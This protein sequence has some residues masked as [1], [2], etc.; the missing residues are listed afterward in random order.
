M[1]EAI[2]HLT[3]GK[4]PAECRWV[5]ARL[6]EAYADE[7]ARIGVTCEV[8]DAQD[9]LPASLLMRVSG[10]G[11]LA[12]V[13]ERTGT[14][15]WIGESPFRPRHK[16]RNWFVGVSLA[17][18]PDD[19]PDLRDSDIDFQA[20]R[21]SGPGGQHV[22]KTD[23]A[24]RATHRPTGLVATAQEQRSQHANR[25]LA[26]LKL[27]MLLEDRRSGASDDVRHEQWSVHQQLERG[28]PVRTYTGPKF[29]R[30]KGG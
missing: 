13:R 17:P 6:A 25:K 14:I 16:R 5:V 18:T 28:N 19:V 29:K 20:M 30:R 11:A 8:L 10:D 2:L 4:G 3:S 1:T 7:A 24:V 23:S 26:K 21:A 12:F 15:L 9:E 27:A 22:N